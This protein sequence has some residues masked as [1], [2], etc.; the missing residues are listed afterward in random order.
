MRI[1]LVRPRYSSLFSLANPIR[2]EP[3]DLEYLAAIAGAEKIE[4]KIH[5]EV[6]DRSSLIKTLR[7]YQPS[8]VALT[9]Y[10]SIQDRIL[11]Y[12][13]IIKKFNSNITVLVG[14]VHAEINFREFQTAHI[15]IIVLSGGH[16][17]FRGLIQHQ[18]KNLAKLPGIT[19]RERDNWKMNPRFQP[20]IQDTVLP[21][22]SHFYKHRRKF[23]YH[24]YGS[25][26]LVKSAAGCPFSCNFCYCRLLNDGKYTARP[27]E[28]VIHEIK[29]IQHDLIWIVDDDFLI[30][31]KRVEDFVKLNRS[32]ALKK[33]YI[34]YGRADFVAQ[35]PQLIA[36]LRSV[37]VIDIIIGFETLADADL[38]A[39]EKNVSSQQNERCATVLREAGIQCTALF[40][41][42]LESTSNTFK[43]LGNWIRKNE[44]ELFTSSIFTPFPGT[45]IYD[46][47][48][49]SLLTKNRKHWDMLHLVLKPTNLGT[50]NFYLQFY[51]LYLQLIFNNSRLRHFLLQSILGRN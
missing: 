28:A 48:S 47:Y 31:E 25:A 50:L 23:H 32:E 42:P 3:L 2:T 18:F 27:M 17:T 33:R 45:K 16:S 5:D 21:D 41:A 1:L 49:R 10:I 46:D 35:Q 9:G 43:T 39:Y 51:R 7:S 38:Q 40:I 15:D 34:I 14:G 11:S 36:E 4:T 29:S 26:A 44:L 19:Y 13:E 8:V 30:D 20:A 12:A 37:G 6:I 22:R 24:Y